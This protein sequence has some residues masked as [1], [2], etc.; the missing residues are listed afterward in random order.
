VQK[1]KGSR[2]GKARTSSERRLLPLGL[3][4]GGVH[5]ASGRG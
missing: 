3:A 5:R 2:A 1:E 4:A